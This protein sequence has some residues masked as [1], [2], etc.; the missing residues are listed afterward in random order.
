MLINQLI[1]SWEFPC[2]FFPCHF[3]FP[4]WFQYFIFVFNFCQFDYYVSWCAPLWVNPAWYSASW[5]WL[6]I[7]F[8]MLGNFSAIISSNIFFQVPFLSPFGIPVMQIFVPLVLSQK[9]LRLFSF[10]KK[11][12]F[13][14]LYSILW[15]DFHYSVFHVT[16]LFFWHSYSA[17]YSF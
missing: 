15:C 11:K 3:S 8:P 9:S 7:S 17:S 16:Y 13:F 14:F 10:L 12:K 1:S 4:C 5:T 2:I 6:T